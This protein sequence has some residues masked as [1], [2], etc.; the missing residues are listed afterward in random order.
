[1][2]VNLKWVMSTTVALLSS[3]MWLV[4]VM[5]ELPTNHNRPMTIGSP[6]SNYVSHLRE[7]LYK[8]LLSQCCVPIALI[9]N[10]PKGLPV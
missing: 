5:A 9:L 3:S 4:N 1:M 6:G 10:L 2:S 7:R 8:T